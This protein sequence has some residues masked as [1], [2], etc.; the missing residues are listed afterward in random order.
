MAIGAGLHEITISFTLLVLIPL[1]LLGRFENRLLEKCH[2]ATCEII[3][4]NDGGK[5]EGELR[6]IFDEYELSLSSQVI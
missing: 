1:T 5:T 6:E 4:L 2:Y 3:H